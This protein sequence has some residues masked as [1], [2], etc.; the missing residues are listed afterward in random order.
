MQRIAL[1]RPDCYH[2]FTI[3][4]NMINFSELNVLTMVESR[5]PMLQSVLPIK[6]RVSGSSGYVFK[7]RVAFPSV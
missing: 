4:E 6:P 1:K 2:S 3:I 7:H 5:G